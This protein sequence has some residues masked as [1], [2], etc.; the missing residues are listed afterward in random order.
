VSPWG[1]RTCVSTCGFCVILSEGAAEVEES[2]WESDTSV[3]SS[4]RERATE[5]VRHILSPPHPCVTMV[6]CVILSEALAESKDPTERVT[7]LGASLAFPHSK[8]GKCQLCWRMRVVHFCFFLILSFWAETKAKNLKHSVLVVSSLA[9]KSCGFSRFFLNIPTSLVI[10]RK[11]S[12]NLFLINK[13]HG[14][15]LLKSNI[16]YQSIKQN[17]PTKCVGWFSFE[18]RQLH[19]RMA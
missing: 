17:H 10:L 18:I 3:P 19:S 7:R 16:N 4:L 5:G 1:E 6:F 8:G 14:N 15:Y 12:K 9:E 13:N 11:H 2:H